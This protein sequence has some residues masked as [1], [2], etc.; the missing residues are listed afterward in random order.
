MEMLQ[1]FLSRKLLVALVALI[2]CIVGAF[3]PEAEEQITSLGDTI[4]TA[5][6]ALIAAIYM[7]VQGKVDTEKEKNGGG[8]K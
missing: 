5:V 2:A 3:R 1:K 4:A 6:P 7:I 8:A